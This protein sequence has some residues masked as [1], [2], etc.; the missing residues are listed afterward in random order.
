MHAVLWMNNN[1]GPEDNKHSMI[2]V[3][4]NKTEDGQKVA[5]NSPYGKKNAY[6]NCCYKICT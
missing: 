4:T 6:G 2:L 3:S 5:W 1:T